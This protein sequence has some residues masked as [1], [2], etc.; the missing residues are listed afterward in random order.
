MTFPAGMA[1]RSTHH[2]VVVLELQAASV[3][4]SAL[5]IPIFTARELSRGRGRSCGGKGHVLRNE[6]ATAWRVPHCEPEVLTGKG[7]RVAEP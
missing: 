3:S 7:I 4:D 5:T 2:A 6:T 1:W